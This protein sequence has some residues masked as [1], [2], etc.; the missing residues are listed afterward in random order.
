MLVSLTAL[1][2]FD[3]VLDALPRRVKPLAVEGLEEVIKGMHLESAY[4]ILIVGSYE[5]DIRSGLWIERLEH[6]E[7]AQLGHLNVQEDEVRPERLD[8]I[9]CFTTI[10]TFSHYLDF[11]ILGQHLANHLAGEWFIVDDQRANTSCV[12]HF[13][14]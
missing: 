12:R 8:R 7:A 5:D 2:E 9:Y 10:R 11:R 6:L 13:A 3:L 4:G 1:I 14:S